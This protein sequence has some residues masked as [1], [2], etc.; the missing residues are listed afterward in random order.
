MLGGSKCLG[1]QTEKKKIL[2]YLATFIL[3]LVCLKQKCSLT[4]FLHELAE[5]ESH[6]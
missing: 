2:K 4:I 3:D 6:R 1:A 5:D